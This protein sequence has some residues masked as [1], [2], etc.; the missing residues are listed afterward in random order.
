M[1]QTIWR[2]IIVLQ[3]LYDIILLLFFQLEKHLVL[4]LHFLPF[5]WLEAARS[6]PTMVLSPLIP[7]R[8]PDED[9]TFGIIYKIV[10]VSLNILDQSYRIDLTHLSPCKLVLWPKV[11]FK[12]VESGRHIRTSWTSETIMKISCIAKF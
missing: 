9:S 3:K 11:H 2:I 10:T 8:H 12:P 1:F 6:F 7:T 4:L 5:N